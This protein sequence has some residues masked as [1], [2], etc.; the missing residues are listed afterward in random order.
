MAC[1]VK[2]SEEKLFKEKNVTNYMKHLQLKPVFDY[3]RHIIVP[4]TRGRQLK[5]KK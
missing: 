2:M 5:I 1:W 4:L 3:R